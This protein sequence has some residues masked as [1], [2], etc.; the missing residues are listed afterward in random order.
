MCLGRRV[1]KDSTVADKPNIL[2]IHSHDTGRYIQPYGHAIPTPNLQRLAEQ[3]VLFRRAFC[4]NPTCSPSRAALVTGTYPHQNGMFGLAHRGW[5]LNNYDEHIVNTFKAAGY[6][7]VLSGV[8]HVAGGERINDIGY[9]E[10]LTGGRKGSPELAASSFLHRQTNSD[11]PFFLSVGFFETHRKFPEDNWTADP[12]HV[13]P[14]TP[15]PDSKELR[16]DM[17]AFIT[18]AGVLDHKMGVVF[19]SLNDAGLRDNTLVICTT[20]H[21]IAFPR[22]KCNLHDTGIGIMLIMHGG[23]FAGGKAVD[24]LASHVDVVPTVCDVAGIDAPARCEGVSLVPLAT[25]NTEEVREEIHAE[26]NYHAC[27]EPMRC[28]RTDRYKY[29]KRFDERD[30]PILPNCDQ[31]ITKDFAME[32]G[33][34]PYQREML[35]DTFLDPHEAHNLVDDPGYGQVLT[36]M[37]QRMLRWQEAT[38]DPVLDGPIPAPPGARV[39]DINGVSPSETAGSTDQFPQY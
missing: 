1:R 17:A 2:Y 26:V 10:L 7:T 14:P 20:D 3:G 16:D 32:A 37:Q 12:N 15:F 4:A 27:Y 13:M 23:P 33:W 5:A 25:G 35:F 39:N 29:I 38:N 9:D 6:R 22:M 30:R 11:Q 28:V 21:G 18:S 24:G 19:D 31:S 34:Y 36:D 8:Q